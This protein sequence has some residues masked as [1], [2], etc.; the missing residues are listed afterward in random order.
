[1]RGFLG[2]SL[3]LIVL[4]VI[5]QPGSTDRLV[6]GNNALM[7]AFRRALSGEVPAIP[8]K[9]KGKLP[10]IIPTLPGSTTGTTQ[11]HSYTI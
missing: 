4:Y 9:A 10:N 8:N 5:L 2:G 3:G 11:P 6:A 7:N 1:M